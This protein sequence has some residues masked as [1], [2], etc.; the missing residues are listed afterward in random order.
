MHGCLSSLVL[1]TSIMLLFAKRNTKNINFEM[2]IFSLFWSFTILKKFIEMMLDSWVRKRNLW[3]D[4]GSYFC[5]FLQC[6][7]IFW[8][9][10]TY[11]RKILRFVWFSCQKS[12]MHKASKIVEKTIK[13]ID[14]I[15]PPSRFNIN[16]PQMKQHL[17]VTWIIVNLYFVIHQHVKE[18]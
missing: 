16:K 1:S 11:E 9:G 14:T 2:N 8:K 10:I 18:F 15:T 3:K 13:H 6:E 17:I 7:Q 4:K 12:K 5:K